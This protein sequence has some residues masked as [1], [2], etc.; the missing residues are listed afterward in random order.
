[1]EF[2]G[3][4]CLFLVVNFFFLRWKRKDVKMLQPLYS[5]AR[6]LGKI[7]L[8]FLDKACHCDPALDINLYLFLYVCIY[9]FTW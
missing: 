1:M 6:G 8:V 4:M 2:Y 9:I 3:G 5:A 7:Q